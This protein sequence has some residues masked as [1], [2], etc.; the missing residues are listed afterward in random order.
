MKK[1][2]LYAVFQWGP[3]GVQKSHNSNNRVAA[4]QHHQVADGHQ[5][6]GP[7]GM[8]LPPWDLQ[9]ILDGKPFWDSI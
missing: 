4:I 8:Y 6:V 9:S 3:A 5:E 1:L 7:A 2:V